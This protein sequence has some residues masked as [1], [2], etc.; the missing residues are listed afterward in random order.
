[1]FA[2][3]PQSV[4][5][6]RKIELRIADLKFIHELSRA[7]EADASRRCDVAR[8]PRRVAHV[9]PLV[10]GG[11][12][13]GGIGAPSRMMDRTIPVEAGLFAG[14]PARGGLKKDGA[15][16]PSQPP[17]CG[18]RRAATRHAVSRLRGDSGRAFRAAEFRHPDWTAPFL[19]PAAHAAAN[20]WAL[21][22]AVK[23]T[24]ARMRDRRSCLKQSRYSSEL[25]PTRTAGAADTV[26][27]AR[28]LWPTVVCPRPPI[29]VG[30]SSEEYLLCFR[31]DRLSAF[32]PRCA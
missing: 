3:H 14:V 23:R 16:R 5:D 12:L 9:R 26:G 2:Q 4:A 10:S 11:L 8:G 18:L 21:R 31:Q 19:Q 15:V 1:M 13:K 32:E 25:R 22:A 20:T 17:Y 6:C 7:S 29:L 24:E 27:D 28:V 30:R